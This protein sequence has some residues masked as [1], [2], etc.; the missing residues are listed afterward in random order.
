VRDTGAVPDR[1]TIEARD[2]PEQHRYVLTVDG[3][4]AGVSVYGLHGDVIRFI[5]TQVDRAF[6][7]RGLGT[8]LARFALDD[9]RRRGLRV[10]ADCPFIARFIR[11]HPAYQDLL[12]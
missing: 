5:H 6:G 8:R 9:A 4:I 7:G 12:G 2:Q 3:A 11:M 10:I 1:S